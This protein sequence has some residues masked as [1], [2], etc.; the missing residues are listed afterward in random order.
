MMKTRGF[1]LIELLVVLGIIGALA[2]II[3]PIS[4]S[5]I[6]KSRE[7]ACLTNFRSLGVGLQAYLQEHN[8]KM[9]ELAAGRTSKVEDIPVLD[10]LL[11]PYLESP[12]AFHCPA[13]KKEFQKSGSSYLW[14]STQNG[15]HVSQLVFFGVKG[16]PDRIPLIYEKETWHP[17]GMNFLFADMS[18]SNKLRF[19]AGN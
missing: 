2:A 18:S 6:G 12:D 10:S 16:R 4:R 9:P 19:A 13:D 11:L 7:A 17:S 14:N 1:T 8:D 15:R 5:M 3:Y